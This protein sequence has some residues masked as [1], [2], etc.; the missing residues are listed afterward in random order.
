MAGRNDDL[1]WLYRR[2][3]DDDDR[4]QAMGDDPDPTRRRGGPSP[5]ATR[6]DLP[7]AN[8]GAERGRR[9]SFGDEG[10]S[11]QPPRKKVKP[12]PPPPPPGQRGRS[13]AGAGRGPAGRSDRGGPPA[14]PRARKKRKRHPF[15]WIFLLLVLWLAF[16]VATPVYALTQTTKTNAEP[17]GE[18]P[19]QQP[20]MTY[21][22]VGSDSREG[23]SEEDRKKLGTGSAEG[24][25][26]DTIMIL[27]VPPTGRPALVS[28]P[29]D[30]YV[31]IPGHGKNKIN[32]AFAFGGPQLLVQTVEQNTGM[33]IDGY[34]EIGFGGFVGVIDALGGIEMCPKQ[35]IKD[36]NAHLDI[37]AGCQ[38]MD[39]IT[40]LGY[41]RARYFDP[42]GDIGRMN[43]QREMVAGIIK[44]AATPMTVLN[45]VRWW[46]LNTGAAQSLTVGENTGP[47]DLARF[48]PGMMQVAEG[49]GLTLVV[50]ISNPNASTAAGSSVLW[51]KGQAQQMFAEM[52]G[53]DTSKLDRFAI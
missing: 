4:T 26:T 2:E 13:S 35:A 31:S 29:R 37:P 49:K 25:R 48:V 24:Q 51:D 36:Q 34:I 17:E 27:Y 3:D 8:S 23:L 12:V 19:G 53:G 16:I 41:V 20:G 44:K 30:S 39:G 7:P 21:L 45:P 5:D 38:E 43:R 47:I 11:A 18:R 1:D 33:R 52:G 6:A 28:L 46:R 22:L 10:S 15:R 9:A 40:S 32:A 14:P 42:T 50:P